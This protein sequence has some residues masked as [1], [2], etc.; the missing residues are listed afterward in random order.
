M[1]T[2]GPAFQGLNFPEQLSGVSS[3]AGTLRQ[4][5]AD[6]QNQQKPQERMRLFHN[7]TSLTKESGLV[8]RF[9]TYWIDIAHVCQKIGHRERSRHTPGQKRFPT[10]IPRET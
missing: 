1:I 5:S 9:I 10:R 4:P 2:S 3:R 7:F 6:Q 8:L